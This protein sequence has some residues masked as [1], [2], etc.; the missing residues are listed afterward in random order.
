MKKLAKN[1]A[2]K[3]GAPPPESEDE[4]ADYDELHEYFATKVLPNTLSI[5]NARRKLN[6]KQSES[7]SKVQ[8]EILKMVENLNSKCGQKKSESERWRR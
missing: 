1:A 4:E 6:E 3:V 2:K 8:F 7:E 5:E